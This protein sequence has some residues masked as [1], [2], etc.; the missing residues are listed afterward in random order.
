MHAPLAYPSVVDLRLDPMAFGD[1]PY[2]IVRDL[3]PGSHDL[4]PTEFYL[5][6]A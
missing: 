6:A 1:T 3:P 5:Q 4:D 2:S